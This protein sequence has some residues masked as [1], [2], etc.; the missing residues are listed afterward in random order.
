MLFTL[1][2]LSKSVWHLLSRPLSKISCHSLCNPSASQRYGHTALIF[3]SQSFSNLKSISGTALLCSPCRLPVNQ[4]H[5]A[6]IFTK[7]SVR[8]PVQQFCAIHCATFQCASTTALQY[9]LCNPP[10]NQLQL[11]QSLKCSGFS[12]GINLLCAG[13]GGRGGG[14]IKL[15]WS[16]WTGLDFLSPQKKI[17][18][19]IRRFYWSWR[20]QAVPALRA[21]HRLAGRI[22]DTG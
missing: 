6:V 14:K 4:E 1:Q 3:T 8:K 12:T 5:S 11:K 17:S 19:K 10:I 2:S 9:L 7:Q 20:K 15:K 16:S 13:R 18:L 21:A 22:N